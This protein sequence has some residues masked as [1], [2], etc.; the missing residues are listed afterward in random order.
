MR[1]LKFVKYL[2]EFG[3]EP[4]VLTVDAETFS[5]PGEYTPDPTLLAEVPTG[6]EVIRVGS[7]EPLRLKRA[8]VRLKLMRLAQMVF[9]PW[10]W[11]RQVAWVAPAIEAALAASSTSRFDAIYTCSGPYCSNWIGRAV[12][13]RTGTPWIADHRDPW[14]SAWALHWPSRVHHRWTRRWESRL[15]TEAD[16]FVANTPGQRFEALSSF[17]GLD[18]ERVVAI[19]NGYDQSDFAA[20]VGPRGDSLFRIVH[21]GS[22]DAPTGVTVAGHPIRRWLRDH[23]EYRNREYDRTSHGP[24]TLFDALTLIR[25]RSP[26]TYARLQVDLVGTRSSRWAPD[27]EARSLGSSVTLHPHEPHADAVA[28]MRQ[29]DVLF[30]PSTSRTDGGRVS[31]V[32][33]KLYEYL[34]AGPPI[35]AVTGAGDAADIVSKTGA[36]IVVPQRDPAALAAA[37]VGLMD[38]STTVGPRVEQ[39]V[40][41]YDRRELTKRLATVLDRAVAGHAVDAAGGD[42]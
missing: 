18:A 32:S 37:I 7:A 22:F 35:I 10:L 21:T 19:T 3:W 30:L 2:R 24:V 1:G 26:E 34:R 28:R 36:G 12:R 42:V 40:A 20:P 29:A 4:T 17:P 14:T 13:Q 27:V 11:E 38:G 8:L 6:V 5:N 41:S 25:D 16:A 9:Y 33:Q 15:L 31:R 39:A 23:L